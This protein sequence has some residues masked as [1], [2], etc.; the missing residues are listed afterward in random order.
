MDSIRFKD[1][2]EKYEAN[3]DQYISNLGR[4]AGLSNTDFPTAYYG[5][6]YKDENGQ[7]KFDDSPQL[8][9]F[10]KSSEEGV[11]SIKLNLWRWGCGKPEEEPRTMPEI[12]RKIYAESQ[13]QCFLRIRIPK[14][15]S[16][17]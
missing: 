6:V 8:R 16:G 3:Y 2:S 1:W 7:V 13:K 17:Y 9:R 11:S 5:L 14:N 4:P 15:K 12:Q 10:Q